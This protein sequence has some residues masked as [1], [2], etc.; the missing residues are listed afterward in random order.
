VFF[1]FETEN[2]VRH[3][4]AFC[5]GGERGI[6]SG[7]PGGGDRK[8][9]MSRSLRSLAFLFSGLLRT[10]PQRPENKNASL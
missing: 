10:S 6:T 2:V 8:Q 5:F 9:G 7:D 4:T 1:L 3:K